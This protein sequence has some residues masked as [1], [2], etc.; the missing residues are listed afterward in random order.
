[1]AE[2]HGINAAPQNTRF[3]GGTSIHTSVTPFCADF[4]GVMQHCASTHP[5][6]DTAHSDRI[7]TWIVLSRAQGIVLIMDNVALF[8]THSMVVL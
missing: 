8:I 6:S 4:D 7:L 2:S 5:A 1:M 3:S